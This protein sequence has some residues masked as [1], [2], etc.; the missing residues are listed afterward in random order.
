MVFESHHAGIG[1]QLHVIGAVLAWAITL[2]RILLL[3]YNPNTTIYTEGGFCPKHSAIDGC[4]FQP[5]SKCSLEDAQFDRNTTELWY[6][7]NGGD[8]Q[9]GRQAGRQAGRQTDRQV[10]GEHPD[11]ETDRLASICTC[12]DGQTDGQ[13]GLW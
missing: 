1:S 13:V 3:A 9:V 5:V 6:M 2:N 11:W 10:H 8:T 4:F 12:R 7:E